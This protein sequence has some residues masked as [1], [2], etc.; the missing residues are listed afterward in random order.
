MSV[1]TTKQALR[2]SRVIDQRTD[3]VI[4]EEDFV[5]PDIKPDILNA[6]STSGTVCI[7]KKELNS[8]KIKIDG[9]INTYIIY[10]ADDE[11][12]SIRA[13]NTTLDFS[14][15][16]DIESAK[17][18]MYLES[19]VKLKTIECRVLNG[20][21]I[22]IKAIVELEIK[23]ISNEEFEFVNEIDEIKDIQL[24]NKTLTLNSMLGTGITK[25]YAKDTMVIDSSDNLEEVMRTDISIINQ[26]TKISYNKVLVKADVGVKIMYLTDDGRICTSTQIIPAMG[27]IDMADV[28]EENLCEVNFELKNLIIKPNNV[29]EH[30]IYIEAELEIACNVSQSREMNIIQDLYSPSVNIVYK[31]KQI[32]AISRREIL[33][34]VCSI[35]EKQFITEIGNHKIFDA[36][37]KP[38]ILNT[39]ILNGRMMYEGQIELSF[40]FEV[41]NTRRIDTKNVVIP[42]TFN[43]DCQDVNSTCNI[44]TNIEVVMQD[45]TVMPDGGIEVKIDLEFKACLSKNEIIQ[46]IEE[47]NIDENRSNNTCSLV[48][49]FVKQGDTLWNIAKRFRSTVDSIVQ[50]NNIQ[51]EN[52]INVG[53]QLFI[54]NYCRC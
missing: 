1:N 45:F 37:I 14:K 54:P 16:L 29:E 50:M 24:L 43:M 27:F 49:Y 2:L 52:N 34:D 32:Q 26:E 30:S 9:C 38:S 28:S 25:V 35:R 6:I 15:I 22:S 41:E 17:Q 36:Y 23:I 33:K 3:T 5:V 10:L 48:I 53:Q 31:Q 12:S 4:V 46:V 13:L 20:R 19:K 7:Y 18:D 39:R 40:F 47:I 8:G 21:K 11:N 51:D 44:D 42:F